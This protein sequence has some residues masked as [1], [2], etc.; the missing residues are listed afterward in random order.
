[1]E[2]I[3]P[4]NPNVSSDFSKFREVE[5]ETFKSVINEADLL[6]L[7]AKYSLPNHVELIPTGWDM[8]QHH[9][10]RY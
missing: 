3:A 7:K 5:S 4:R 2:E 9:R 1:M 8:V 6:E 10:S